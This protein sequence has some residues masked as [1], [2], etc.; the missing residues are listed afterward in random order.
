MD[1][2]GTEDS[3]GGSVDGWVGPLRDWMGMAEAR[4]CSPGK[5]V[6][7]AGEA[8]ELGTRKSSRFMG[9][10]D[11]SLEGSMDLRS[12]AIPLGTEVGPGFFSSR[13]LCL[14]RSVGCMRWELVAYSCSLRFRF[15]AIMRQ[16]RFSKRS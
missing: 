4:A 2:G 16:V 10:A 9:S 8:M 5:G 11:N 12:C 14:P 15:M 13:C 3:G 6:I 1:G 7:P